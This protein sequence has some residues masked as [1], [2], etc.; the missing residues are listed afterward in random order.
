MTIFDLLK[1]DAVLNSLFCYHNLLL[2]FVMERSYTH[3]L[4]VFAPLS[5]GLIWTMGTLGGSGYLSRC[6]SGS[7]FH[8]TRTGCG[9]WSIRG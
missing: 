7:I 6:D 1:R 9:I 4:L 5:L 3:G 2:L 8:D